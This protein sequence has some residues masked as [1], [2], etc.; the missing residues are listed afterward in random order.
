MVVVLRFG[1][2]IEV[3]RL[4]E[5]V[6]LSVLVMLG[7]VAVTQALVALLGTRGWLVALFLVVLQLTSAGAWFPVETAPGFFQAIHPL[8]PMS[9]AV[10]GFR[11][12]VAG[13]GPSLGPAVAV[14]ILW[15][16]AAFVATL[17]AARVRAGGGTRQAAP[18][19]A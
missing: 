15:A 12:L 18:V 16:A 6:A 1:V 11:T 5:L 17:A 13:G 14:V 10:E 4:P 9:Y 19:A 8:L 2:G 3:A 7:V